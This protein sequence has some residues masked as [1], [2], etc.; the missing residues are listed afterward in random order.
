M[1]LGGS[2]VRVSMTPHQKMS[3]NS[4]TTSL[5]GHQ[6]WGIMFRIWALF[7]ALVCEVTH[8]DRYLPLSTSPPCFADLSWSIWQQPCSLGENLLVLAF[9]M[10]KR[11]RHCGRADRDTE[12]SLCE[13]W[14]GMYTLFSVVDSRSIGLEIMVHYSIKYTGGQGSP[15]GHGNVA[16]SLLL[17]GLSWLIDTHYMS[18]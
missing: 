8:G 11:H 9:L 17:W 18:T 2:G 6:K 4:S 16:C 7:Y 12:A 5:S 10:E 3:L 15:Y 1:K 14:R 13:S